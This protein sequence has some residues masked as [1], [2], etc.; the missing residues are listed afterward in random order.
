MLRGTYGGSLASSAAM[1]TPLDTLFALAEHV[2]VLPAGVF[3]GAL[4]SLLD[5]L[6]NAGGAA[7]YGLVALALVLGACGVP[8]PEEAVF[9]IGGA[10]AASGRASVLLVYLLGWAVVLALDVALHGL[11]LRYGQDLE[12]SRVGRRVGPERWARLRQFVERRGLWAVLAARFVM[13]VRIPTFVL[14]GAMGMPRRHFLP[15]VA[16]AGLVSGALPLALGYALGTQLDDVL[17]WLG[18]VRWI[19]F[20][21]FVAVLVWWLVRRR[22]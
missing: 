6:R 3:D 5:V 22:S 20:G 8:I 4:A 12:Q 1:H 9:A 13:G 21:A 16:L 17:T 10:L 18:T 11:G 7:A 14:A 2:D 15:V 19:L